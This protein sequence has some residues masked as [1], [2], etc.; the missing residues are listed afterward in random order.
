M[1][2]RF[3]FYF[4]P[5]SVE[6]RIFSRWINLVRFIKAYLSRSGVLGTGCTRIYRSPL[7]VL[8]FNLFNA[9]GLSACLLNRRRDNAIRTRTLFN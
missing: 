3:F 6:S 5:S 2:S 9:S 7:Y 8:L 4:S 1:T